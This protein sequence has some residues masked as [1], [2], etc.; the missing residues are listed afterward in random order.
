MDSSLLKKL[1]FYSYLL[2]SLIFFSSIFEIKTN[3]ILKSPIQLINHFKNK[4]TESNHIIIKANYFKFKNSNYGYSMT[5]RLYYDPFIV[6]KNKG[7]E[8]S[9]MNYIKIEKPKSVDDTPI[10]LIEK[11]DCSFTSLAFN[12]N[13]IG[14]KAVLVIEDE[15]VEGIAP[16]INEKEEEEIDKSITHINE[17]NVHIPLITISN[18]EGKK[19]VEFYLK[20]RFK[21]EIIEN[22][23]VE[24]EYKLESIKKVKTEFFFSIFN[25]WVYDFLINMKKY[26]E[27][28]K[29]FF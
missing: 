1:S 22:I 28:C 3:L 25:P 11:G 20:N 27:I 5:G 6:N 18:K 9:L 21:K 14:A 12:A 24:I 26:K 7:C 4:N 16:E 8:L 2:I 17:S 15:V 10:L 13:E 29:F 23:K 19:L